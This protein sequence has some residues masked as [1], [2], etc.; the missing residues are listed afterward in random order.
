MKLTV[1][2]VFTLPPGKYVDHGRAG[3]ILWVKSATARSWV[4][5]IHVQG[6]RR[7]IGLGSANM[8][9][10]RT[11]REIA[12]GNQVI[13]RSGGDPKPK[14]VVQ[15]IPTLHEA[16]EPV[17]DIQREQWKPGSKSEAQWRST[18]KEY[19]FPSLGDRLVSEITTPQIMAVL[20]PLWGKKRE[21]ASRI[22]QRISVIMQWAITQGHRSDNPVEATKAVLKGAKKRNHQ[23]S[24]HHDKIAAALSKVRKSSAFI[25]TKLC[26]EFLTLTATRSGEARG[27]RWSEVQGKVWTIPASR[28]KTNH[29]LR[30][31]LSKGALKVLQEAGKFTSGS[32]LI[33]PS[34]MNKTLSDSTISKLFR[35][36]KLGCVPHGMRSS[37]RVWSTET[38]YE[39]QVC[40]FALGHVENNE[41]VR[42][43]QRSD[44]FKKRVALMQDWSDYL[45]S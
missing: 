5:Q 40:E 17:L 28:T 1:K 9:P 42:A 6:K 33:F 22:R 3:L 24:L 43:Y 4:Q 31:P 15:E 16:L 39:H 18:L 41:A 12:H 20:E 30:I 11:A 21:T 36:L 10:L 34:P 45:N 29:E 27:A 38:D 37:F 2:D 23:K 26:A 13:A 35:E 8:V 7:T 14:I 32:D 19:V 44:L 25:S